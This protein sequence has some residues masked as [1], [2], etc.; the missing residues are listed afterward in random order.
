MAEWSKAHDWKS[1]VGQPTVGSN[2]TLSAIWRLTKM[3]RH[4]SKSLGRFLE[5]E[6]LL[7]RK[8]LSYTQMWN[9][10]FKAREF[11]RGKGRQIEDIRLSLGM[12]RKRQAFWHV[13]G[14]AFV[15]QVFEW[16]SSSVGRAPGSQSGGRGFDPH[17]LHHFF[18]QEP[19][20]EWPGDWLGHELYLTGSRISTG[21]C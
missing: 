7:S 18:S 12:I 16:G 10:C 5:S 15:R 2:P 20:G 4:F 6:K 13:V 1:C 8:L 19:V 14:A 21:S 3:T 9:G 11:L 17:L